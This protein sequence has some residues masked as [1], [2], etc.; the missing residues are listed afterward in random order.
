MS[1][2]EVCPYSYFWWCGYFRS[3][4]VLFVL[5]NEFSLRITK[6]HQQL[7]SHKLV[8]YHS[9]FDQFLTY[10]MTILS[11]ACKPVNF[12]AHNS[13]KF[14]LNNIWG[15]C[16]NF[17]EC[18]YVLESNAP[19][20]IT[21]CE[22]NM[23]DSTDSSN[24]SVRSYFP[25]IQKDSVTRMHGLAVCL[26]KGK[27]SFCIGLISSKIYGF[28]VM[29]STDFTSLSVLLLFPLMITFFILMQFLLIFHQ[30]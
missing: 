4:W 3:P 8:V 11:K 15:L 17:F 13:L 18:E 19:D 23:D 10:K 25:L 6:L 20:I 21:L 16:L 27:T 28:L 5:T 2:K 14:N 7:G 30:T 26:Y 12:E 24:F 22:T 1:C 9:V 29:F